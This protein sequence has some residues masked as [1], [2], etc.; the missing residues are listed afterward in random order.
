MEYFV[1]DLD[2][3]IFRLGAFGPR[4]YGVMFAMG[5]LVGLNIMQW[6]YKREGKDENNLSSLLVHVMVGTI[7]GARLG[8]CLFYQPEYYLSNPLKIL[9]IWEGGLASH[10]GTIGVILASYLYSRKHKD[11]NLLWI[12][13]RMAVPL[14]FAAGCIRVGNFFNSEIIGRQTDAP[15]A[16]VFSR[17]DNLP[18]HPAMLY[19]AAA[20]WS[21][22]AVLF[23]L[24]Q[25]G[26]TKPGR[27][28]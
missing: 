20:Y 8:H 18:R 13:D 22:F 21:L 24:Y 15:W 6:Q 9:A 12:A 27:L 4:Y 19:E 2:P 10:G 28:F 23:F 1:W 11:E 26:W 5:F 17:V 14:A 25:R 7:L 16:I 3:E